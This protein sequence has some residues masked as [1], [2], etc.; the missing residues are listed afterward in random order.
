MT[1][2]SARQ[3]ASNERRVKT[4][5]RATR[6]GSGMQS[7]SRPRPAALKELKNLAGKYTTKS[8]AGG[9]ATN[10][11]RAS[12]GPNT[13]AGVEQSSMQPLSTSD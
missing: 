7:G 6:I 8:S 9:A 1:N 13:R 2:S 12:T 11:S 10:D 3:D 5:E 4:A